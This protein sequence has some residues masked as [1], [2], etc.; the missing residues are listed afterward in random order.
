MKKIL[1]IVGTYLPKASANGICVSKVAQLLLKEGYSVDCLCM[2]NCQAP[3][4]EDIDGVK[5]YRINGTLSNRISWRLLYGKPSQLLVAVYK[6]VVTLSRIKAALLYP[7]Y[8]MTTPLFALKTLFKVDQLYKKERYDIVV[9]VFQP[10][11]YLWVGTMLKKRYPQLK[12]VL[13]YL[14]ILSGGVPPKGFSAE[15]LMKKAYRWE[16]SFFER[17]DLIII[18]KSYQKHYTGELFKKYQ[19]KIYYGDFPLV[20]EN[21]KARY[22]K[23]NIQKKC[24]FILAGLIQK[25]M[26]NPEYLF[27]LLSRLKGYVSFKFDFCGRHDCDELVHSLSKELGESFCF[28]GQVDADVANMMIDNAD[29]LISIGNSLDAAVPSKIFTYMSTGK[30]ILHLYSSKNDAALYYLKEYPLSLMLYEDWEQLDKNVDK[31]VG[32][33]MNKDYDVLRYGDIENIFI[34]NTP[35][36]FIDAIEKRFGKN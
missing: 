35:K 32:F 6:I 16:K 15:W 5:V 3:E 19:D 26:R 20:V 25:N 10:F 11:S 14:D 13:Y 33:L 12:L 29:V 1:F 28:H 9:P 30:P 36:A 21:D 8:P 7:I 23:R 4:K 34:E 18:M 17:A 24:N 27:A 31:L 2:W 22:V